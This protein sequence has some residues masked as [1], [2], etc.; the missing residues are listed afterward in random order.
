LWLSLADYNTVLHCGDHLTD[1]NA[2]L[3]CGDHLPDY[4]A[5]LYCGDNLPD[6]NAV[7]HC[8]DHLLIITQC[9]IVAI[10]CLII[11]HCCIVAITCLIIMQCCI[12]AITWLIITQCCIV[13]ITCLFLTQSC[14]LAITCLTTQNL[15]SSYQVLCTMGHR[16]YLV[17]WRCSPHPRHFTSPIIMYYFFVEFKLVFIHVFIFVIFSINYRAYVASN[18]AVQN[19]RRS[20]CALVL[21]FLLRV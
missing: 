2:V 17:R 21:A 18:E 9:C 10:T 14:I 16:K 15:I 20:G 12:V 13:A 11:E 4:S 8:G 1:Y 5:V 19:V 3:Y 6:Y 7:L